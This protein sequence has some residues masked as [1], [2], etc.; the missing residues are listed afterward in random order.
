MLNEETPTP[1]HRCAACGDLVRL[2]PNLQPLNEVPGTC[3]CGAETTFLKAG[4]HLPIWTIYDHRGDFQGVFV[5]RLSILDK[6]TTKTLM[7]GTLEGL[8]SQLPTGLT[9]LPRSPEDD[10]VIVECWL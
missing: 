3:T 10:P 4:F 5:A 7:A 1:L 8:R 2:L 6:P 9:C